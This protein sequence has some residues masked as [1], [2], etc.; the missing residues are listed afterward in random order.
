MN[1]AQLRYPAA[2][3]AILLH[4]SEAAD[5]AAT[6]A[7]LPTAPVLIKHPIHGLPNA[8]S[9]LCVETKVLFECAK[10]KRGEAGRSTHHRC[11]QNNGTMQ[12]LCE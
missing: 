5:I 4:A 7:R 12:H 3:L 2:S 9:G 6:A 10:I 11:A 1:N 8:N